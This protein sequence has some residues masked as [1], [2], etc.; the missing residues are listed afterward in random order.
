MNST[1]WATLTEFVKYLG[2]TGKCKVEE[3]PKGWFITY[4][5]RD[6]ETLFKEKTKNKRIKADLV[7]EEKQEKEIQ[8]QI[9]RAEQLMQLSNPESDQPSQVETTRKLN[10][11]DGIKIGFSL[12]PSVKPIAKDKGEALRMAFDEADKEKFE[13]KNHV[14]NLKRKESGGGNQLWMK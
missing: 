14:N 5:D 2:R 13:E 7:D 10:A 6:S 9:E 12:G 1:E 4:I 11:E 3:T 8:K